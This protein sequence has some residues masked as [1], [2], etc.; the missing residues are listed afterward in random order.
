MNP[1]SPAPIAD[2]TLSATLLKDIIVP[3]NSGI[4]SRMRLAEAV[5]LI[6]AKIQA[7]KKPETDSQKTFTLK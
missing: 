7:R 3:R 1:P 4:C 5:Y 6:E 2:P